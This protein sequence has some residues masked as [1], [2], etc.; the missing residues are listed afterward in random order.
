MCPIDNAVAF[1]IPII[2]GSLSDQN[3][4]SIN[5]QLAPSTAFRSESPIAETPG[6]YT[7]LP[8]FDVS[9]IAKPMTEPTASAALSG[10]NRGTSRPSSKT[11]SRA[12][13]HDILEFSARVL[14]TSAMRPPA[15]DHSA[16]RTHGFGVILSQIMP[17][18]TS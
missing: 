10:T 9:S 5:R 18:G 17:F 13:R 3:V 14:A 16:G 15:T 2:M 1:V 7:N 8:P 12:I 11:R 4:P 6:A